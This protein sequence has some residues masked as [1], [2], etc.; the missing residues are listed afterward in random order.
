MSSPTTVFLAEDG[1]RQT[2]D[3]WLGVELRHL[4]AVAAVAETGSFRG[5]AERLGYVQSSI[6]Q[7][8]A[9][10]E[11]LVGLRLIERSR[12]ASRVS[13]T[14]A[15]IRLLE[16]SEVILTR[17]KAAQADLVSL[18]QGT[19]S[20]VRVG[21]DQSV[22]TKLLPR[23]LPM[24]S[25]AWPRASLATT[26]AATDACLFARIEDASL[27][28]AFVDLPLEE[29][30]F[31]SRPL[32]RDPYVLVVPR[33]SRVARLGRP[34]TWREIA[35]LP[36]IGHRTAR[37]LPRLEAQM[38]AQGVEPRFVYRSDINAT[39]QAMV[40]STGGAAVLTRL[41]AEGSDE[42]T[43]IIDLSTLVPPRIIA[44]TWHSNRHLTAA[45]AGFRD[46]VIEACSRLGGGAA[47]PERKDA[48]D[49]G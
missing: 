6:S 5:A 11:R 45:V 38:R 41:I 12:G 28:L 21:V 36:L 8:I 37:F 31:A 14:E 32:L 39:I 34:P 13:L 26:E 27:D 35:K 2:R 33:A 25:G 24:F 1:T 30:P 9:Q 42:R 18:S 47:L 3:D 29:G 19:S 15:G 4:A 46:V 48:P 10:L 43:E 23:I 20:V 7:Q 49:I 22:A 44:L 16:H 17:F 40:A